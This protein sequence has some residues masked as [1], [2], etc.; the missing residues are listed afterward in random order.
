[1]MG[2]GDGQDFHVRGIA[3]FTYAALRRRASSGVNGDC[4]VPVKG[5]S[6]ED[7]GVFPGFKTLP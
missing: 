7:T 1:M 6:E 2:I 5:A 4:H 3:V